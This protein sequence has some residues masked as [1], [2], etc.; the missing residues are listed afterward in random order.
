MNITFIPETHK[1]V[2]DVTGAEY[3]SVTNL[4][5]QYKKPFE[6][7]KWSK[8]VAK[9]D[10]KTQ[11]AVLEA[12]KALTEKAQI[13]GTRYH[14]IMEDFIKDNVIEP[15]YKE[16]IDSFIKKTSNNIKNDS[17]TSS[18]KLLFNHE[19]Q[20]AGTADLIVENVSDFS[21]FDFKTNKSFDFSTKYNE[22]FQ[23]PLE[24]L[25]QCKYSTYS[26]QLSIYAYLQEKI[27]ESQG[28]P[29]RC[30]GLKLFYLREFDQTFWQEINMPYMRCTIETLLADRKMK[31][32]ANP[33]I[34]I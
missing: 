32:A 8:H 9:R 31:N 5:S 2:N 1:Y 13:R 33:A 28:T 4:I 27:F 10:G 26:L 24:Y 18:E 22:Y 12:W 16:L 29:K 14:K 6:K 30:N 20:I 23:S 21:I 7:D 25:S 17:I 11:S 15:G 19:H 3:I 34:C